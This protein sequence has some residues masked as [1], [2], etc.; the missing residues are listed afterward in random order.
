MRSLT[1]ETDAVLDQLPAMLAPDEIRAANSRHVDP[2]TVRPF[3]FA[4]WDFAAPPGVHLPGKAS[5]SVFERIHDGRIAVAGRRYGAIGCGLGVEAVVAAHAGAREILACDVHAPSVEA[6]AEHVRRHAGDRIGRGELVFRPVVSDVLAD[7][8]GDVALDVVTFNAP[9]IAV[10]VSD[11]PDVVRSVS[12]GD[13][14]AERFFVQ[15]AERELLA[16]GGEV[17]LLASNTSDLAAIVRHG[18]AAEFRPEII[19]VRRRPDIK[20]EGH[21]FRFTPE[22]G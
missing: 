15:L 2:Q 14:I 5:V 9:T 3:A 13:G 17:F 18:A 7:V 1:A 10:P 21:L 8:P 20:L 19:H 4:G 16:P 11:D 12:V 22:A 6:A